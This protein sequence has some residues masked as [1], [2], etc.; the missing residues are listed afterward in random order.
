MSDDDSTAEKR[1][2]WN[3][4]DAQLPTTLKEEVLSPA[5]IRYNEKIGSQADA[6]EIMNHNRL[7]QK[8]QRLQNNLSFRQSDME[9]VC[10]LVLNEH[11]TW[12]VREEERGAWAKS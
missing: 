10:A 8:L 1:P 6:R 7:V 2:R 3:G 9:R 4:D 5:W 11:E 12:D